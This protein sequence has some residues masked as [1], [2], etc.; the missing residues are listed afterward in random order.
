MDEHAE[1]E[2]QT[3][4]LTELQRQSQQG[5]PGRGAIALGA[6]ALGRCRFL[7]GDRVDMGRLAQDLGVN[8]ATLYR[9]VGPV[10]RRPGGFVT[11]VLSN[12]RCRIVRTPGR[13][14]R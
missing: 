2:Q 6:L 7:R 8:R 5:A 12:A 1:Q 4:S 11:V 13:H 3:G 14:H 9:W 10:A